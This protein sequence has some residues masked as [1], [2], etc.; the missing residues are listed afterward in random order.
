MS[1]P[2]PQVCVELS[3]SGAGSNRHF[4]RTGPTGTVLGMRRALVG[5]ADRLAGF[6]PDHV[7]SQLEISQF[8]SRQELEQ[9]QLTHLRTL[10][11]HAGRHV[12]FYRDLFRRL[13]FR[14]QDVLSVSDIGHLPIVDKAMIMSEGERFVSEIAARPKVR[15]RTS[16]ST[17]QPFSFVRTR[18][19]QSYKIASRMRFRRWYGIERTDSQLVVSGI[20]PV[21]GSARQSFKHWLHFFAT[22]RVEVYSSEMVGAGLERAASLI[23][24]H[25]LASVMGYPTG[26]AA[27]A[28]FISHDRPLT[29]RPRAVF[30]NSETLFPELRRRIAAGFGVEP[31]S[32]YV[33]TE[34]AIAHEC[35][36]GSMHVNMEETL[37]EIVPTADTPELGEVVLTYLHTYDFPLVRYKVGDVASWSGS[38]CSCGRGLATIDSL[39]GR[40]ADGIKL[41]NG[42][43]YTAANI[44]MRI[45]HLPLIERIRQYQVAQVSESEVELRVTTQDAAANPDAVAELQRGLLAAFDGQIAIRVVRMPELPRQKNG[46]KFRPV[47]GLSSRPSPSSSVPNDSSPP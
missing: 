23:E 3:C 33:A 27:L 21:S 25:Q 32:D 37:M 19:A 35:P 36:M 46:G 11:D 29:C 18:I 39:L 24:S 8:W 4:A 31:R 10:L 20:P 13:D 47:L 40:Y 2:L 43:V 26:I 28:D 1:K 41:P 22:N 7:L 9:Q 17:G 34:G 30:T 38:P 5:I 14:P 44:N 45:A 15:L 12:P 42:L 16:G 6:S